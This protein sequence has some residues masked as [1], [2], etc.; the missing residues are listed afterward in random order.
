LSLWQRFS[1]VFPVEPICSAFTNERTRNKSLTNEK[2]QTHQ[3]FNIA[4]PEV[5]AEGVTLFSRR[6][7]N[8][9]TI[10]LIM[11]KETLKGNMDQ[12]VNPV[13]TPAV[14]VGAIESMRPSVKK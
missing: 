9:S 3:V 4:R 13:I 8:C 11:N 10:R 7:K 14:I 6:G 12:T 2:G 1:K 5:Q